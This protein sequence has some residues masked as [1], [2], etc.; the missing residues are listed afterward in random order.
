MLGK[1]GNY[2][3]AKNLAH[4]IKTLPLP[5]VCPQF[6]CVLDGSVMETKKC[7]C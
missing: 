6:L 2:D 1:T 5:E 7:C 4:S 3:K